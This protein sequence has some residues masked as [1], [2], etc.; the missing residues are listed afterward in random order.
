MGVDYRSIKSRPYTGFGIT[1]LR[2]IFGYGI[3]FYSYEIYSKREFSGSKPLDTMIS[4]ALAGY[5]FW[6]LG[7]P[8]DTLKSIVQSG[9]RSARTVFKDLLRSKRLF[10]LYRGFVPCML[11]AGPVNAATF[12]AYEATMAVLED[13]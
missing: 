10:S 9:D 2:E 3:Y 5:S 8:I 7:Y 6:V 13:K 1:S 11:R 12:L 4:G